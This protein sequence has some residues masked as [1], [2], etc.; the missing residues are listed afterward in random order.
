MIGQTISHYRVIE[1]LGGGGMGVVYK[2]EDTRLHRLV[3]L[4]FLPEHVARDPHALSRFQREAQAASALNHPNICTI[5]DIGEQA[6]QTFISMEFLE[7]ATLKHRIANRPMDLDILLSLGIEIADALDAAHAKGILHRDIKPANIFV[8]DRGHAK[9]LDF[10][11]AKLS[12][13]LITGTEPT[14]A[15]LDTQDHLTSPGAALGTVAYMSPEQAFGKDLDARTDL[16]SFGIVL[17]E[18]ATGKPPFRGET[19]AAIF[20]SILHKVPVAPVR[21]NPD[22]PLRL[23]QIINKVLEKDRNL[24]YQHAA[25]LRADLQRVER[26]TESSRLAELSVRAER[27]TSFGASPN[28]E[29]AEAVISQPTMP[30]PVP[31]AEVKKRFVRDW[32]FLVPAAV[33][34][35]AIAVATLYWRSTKADALTDKDSVLLADFV[36]TTGDPVFDGTLKQAVAV[37]LGESPHFNLV[38]EGKLRETLKLM[39]QPPATRVVPP[40]ARE[41]CQRV[42]AK[43]MVGGS[44]LNL[45]NHYVIDLDATNCLSGGSLAHQQT[46][47]QNRD[48]VLK[49]LGEIISPVRRELGESLNSIQKFDTPIERATTTS[50]AALKAYT[51]GDEKRAQGQEAES[52]P[53]YRMATELDPN[54]AI[55]YARLGAVYRDVGQYSFAD[56]Y[57]KAAFERRE[58][59]SEKEKFYIAAHYYAD[60]TFETEKAIETYKLW[61]ETYSRDWIPFN[62]LSTEYLRIGWAEKAIEPA[63]QA[64]RL[65]PNHGFPYN[66]LSAAYLGAG[67]VAEAKAVAEKAIA[68]HKDGFGIHLTLYRIAF[69]EAD[70]AAQQREIDWFKDQPLRAYNLNQQAWTAAALGQLGKMQ[71]L[72][73]QTR[74]EALH[75]GLSDYAAAS[76]NDEAALDAEFGNIAGARNSAKLALRLAPDSFDTQAGAAVAFALIGDLH[77]ADVLAKR[78]AAK[79]PTNL[80][81]NNVSLA[82]IRAAIEMRRGNFSGAIEQL[83]PTVAYEFADGVSAPTGYGAY[84][85]GLAHLGQRSGKEAAEE[86]QKLL[87]NRGPLAFSPYW[88]LA[89]LGLAR[90]YAMS[91]DTYKARAMYREFLVLWKDADPDIPVI[92]QAKEEY[93]KL[94]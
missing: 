36:N 11:L 74:A 76:T 42:G 59:V 55:A 61:A 67:R 88:V 2:A 21:L 8:T 12:L 78:A 84:C 29:R 85:R 91:G 24:R 70:A 46:Q 25:D 3:A 72:F 62:N 54:F 92:K 34:L 60:A 52:V 77:Q 32:K 37:K 65:N 71:R 4:K 81:L 86:F 50:L 79:S 30:S 33:A 94:K 7:G 23:E 47:A 68:A 53:Y 90:A 28:S 89:H 82:T 48:Q 66:A 13:R 1:R 51:S 57:Q 80:L 69:C 20:D 27:V 63:Q 64:L 39:G 45:G 83:R 26:D 58:H 22:L 19:S 16:F 10:G 44:I 49:S 43:V 73:D 31:R 17:Y 6:G 40:V 41:A 56:Q 5:Y 38:N 15:T 87:D 75:Q 9:V 35:G 14:A 93:A 18:M